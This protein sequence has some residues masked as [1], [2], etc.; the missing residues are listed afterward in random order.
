[1]EQMWSAKLSWLSTI[2]D[3]LGTITKHPKLMLCGKSGWKDQNIFVGVVELKMAFCHPSSHVTVTGRQ[4]LLLLVAHP[5]PHRYSITFL[6]SLETL[7][8]LSTGA[9]F[10]V[11][12]LH[13]PVA[14]WGCD[15]C[16]FFFFTLRAGQRKWERLH[17]EQQL[18]RI[19]HCLF[20]C[21]FQPEPAQLLDPLFD[22]RGQTHSAQETGEWLLLPH[23]V[24]Q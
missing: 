1:M 4:I 13:R 10:Q 19:L 12:L 11:L 6:V 9:Q 18:N 3:F 22:T 15:R 20:S 14:F 23:Q 2:A 5:L 7:F 24:G 16:L 17:R 8:L 21:H